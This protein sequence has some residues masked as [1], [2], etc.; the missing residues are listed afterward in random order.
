MDPVSQP[1]TLPISIAD[2]QFAQSTKPNR[3][4]AIG[5][6]QLS[7][8]VSCFQMFFINIATVSRPTP[9]GTGVNIPATPRPPPD[10]HHQREWPRFS[11]TSNR[12][13]ASS[14]NSDL[15]FRHIGDFIH[16]TSITTAP[17]LMCSPLINPA[18]PIATTSEV[19]SASDGSEIASS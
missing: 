17:G 19:G 2:C 10:A 13:S 12:F 3:Q 5:N 16:S 11:T 6:R 4:S 18:L 9:P 8:S 14:P 7:S 15:Y 1:V